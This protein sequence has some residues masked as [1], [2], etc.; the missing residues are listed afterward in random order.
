MSITTSQ[1]ISRFFEAYQNTDVA[2][3]KEV[4]K[5][6]ELDPGKIHL[7]FGSTRSP[8]VIYS[9]SMTGAK[10]IANLKPVLF[11]LL[12][13]SKN[14]V[15]LR[16]AFKRSDNPLP[17][18]FFVTGKISDLNSYSNNNPETYLISLIYNQKPPDDLI[19]ILGRLLS[20]RA[21]VSQRKEQRII[22]DESSIRKLHIRHKDAFISIDEGQ[23]RKCIVRDLSPSGAQV[24]SLGLTESIVNSAI[25]LTLSFTDLDESIEVP[26]KAVRFESI[27]GRT[28]IAAAAI[29]F[30]ENKIPNA[31]K[32]KISR[33]YS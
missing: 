21:T 1:Q 26:G 23:P 22:L 24:F 18:T 4:I 27:E 14:L 8:C 17:L 25:L 6:T 12:R 15:T 7:K 10:L 28:D 31:Y 9:C 19:E 30:D 5:F 3:N 20:V 2:F 16:F 11:E 32:I 29:R 33:Y 13:E